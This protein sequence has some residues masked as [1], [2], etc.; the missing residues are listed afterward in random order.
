MQSD[1]L[2]MI[3]A[4][5]QYFD[6]RKLYQIIHGYICIIQVTMNDVFRLHLL[7]IS[8][9]SFR[10]VLDLNLLMFIFRNKNIVLFRLV[11]CDD[12]VDCVTIVSFNDL[13]Y[14][15]RE[16]EYSLTSLFLLT[17]IRRKTKNERKKMYRQ[18]RVKLR[19]D[20]K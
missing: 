2:R 8:P 7:S 15:Q 11:Q 16:H 13:I 17:V 1:I 3:D 9:R 10:L 20:K 18:L 14:N 19:V 12:S 6:K 5:N 4:S